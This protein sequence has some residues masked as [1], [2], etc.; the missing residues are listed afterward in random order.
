MAD[1]DVAEVVIINVVVAEAVEAVADFPSLLKLLG[2]GSRIALPVEYV[3][4][5]QNTMVTTPFAKIASA[6]ICSSLLAANRVPSAYKIGKIKRHVPILQS[7]AEMGVGVEVVGVVLVNTISNSS[8]SH[9]NSSTSRSSSN[10]SSR[11][12]SS[13]PTMGLQVL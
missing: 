10:S 12:N 3:V 2:K 4:P 11:N 8:N 9:S 7:N 6:L 13:S 1:E 5:R